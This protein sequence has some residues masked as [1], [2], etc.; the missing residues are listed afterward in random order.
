LAATWYVTLPSPCPSFA[1]VNEI[2]L[3]CAAAVHW[4]SRETAI[5]T[6]PSPP[7]APKLADE[8]DAVSWHRVA[9]G[10]VVLVTPLLPH[11]IDTAAAVV[12]ANSRGPRRVT[13]KCRYKCRST[14]TAR[15]YV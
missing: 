6:V 15:E 12:T 7:D 11:A 10:P 14:G 8:F 2:Q 13:M 4:H 1:G 9:V 3:A 5:V